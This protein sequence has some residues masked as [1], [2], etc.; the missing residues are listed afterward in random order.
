MRDADRQRVV[1]ELRLAADRIASN[2]FER[3]ERRARDWAPSPLRSGLGSSGGRGK[4]N[5]SRPT[6]DAVG[7][8]GVDQA[9]ELDAKVR[10]AFAAAHDVVDLIARLLRTVD[11][12]EV[13]PRCGECGR[14]VVELATARLKDGKCDSCYRRELRTVERDM[15]RYETVAV[16]E[17]GTDIAA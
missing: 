15:V 17:V 4:G 1:V 12:D 11:V 3:A 7:T 9:A 14:Q 13:G 5:V 16:V 2:E 8:L 6:E 10:K